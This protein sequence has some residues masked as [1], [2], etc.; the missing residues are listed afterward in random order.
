MVP[1]S[2]G[3]IVSIFEVMVLVSMGT[4]VGGFIG[5]GINLVRNASPEESKPIDPQKQE[6]WM[7]YK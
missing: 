3:L 2:G 7:K 5:Y 6:K 1:M 4:V